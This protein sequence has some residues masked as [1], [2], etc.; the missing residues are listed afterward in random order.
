[1][2]P[3][4]SIVVPVYNVE[5]YLR[6]AIYS[7]LNQ[8]FD[9]YEVILIDDGSKD[10]SG[11]ICEELSE[12]YSQIHVIHQDNQGLSAARN[13]GMKKAKGK[14]IIFLDSDDKLSPNALENLNSA[15][16][17][18]NYPEVMISRRETIV[19]EQED[20]VECRYYFP[21]RELKDKSRA[22][23]YEQI[24]TYPDMWLGAWIFTISNEYLKKQ[25]LFFYPD[26][27]HEDEEWV[28]R[29]FF[30]S[31]C[32][33]YNNHLLY[34]NRPDRV[35]SITSVPYIKR[36]FDKLFIVDELK[37]EFNKDKY[38]IDV[39]KCINRRCATIIFG[40]ICEIREFRGDEKYNELVIELDN[41]LGVL[42][43]SPRSV[44]RITYYLIRCLGS[45]NVSNF[46]KL[47]GL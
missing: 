14:Y 40:I 12:Q 42:K 32:I 8:K 31:S 26:L 2:K 1:M 5:K 25:S 36:L 17:E 41:K 35:G 45:Y 11:I 20:T 33:G 22:E 18:M 46:L 39:K 21:V 15:I 23:I 9:D 10:S 27:L 19:N 3:M 13:S 37:S 30:N 44:H 34:T 38:D 16:K 43:E 28:P 24:Q 29:V 6:K 7:V 47:F 4:F